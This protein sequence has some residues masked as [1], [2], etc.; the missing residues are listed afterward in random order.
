M[1]YYSFAF[2]NETEIFMGKMILYLGSAPRAAGDY[3]GDKVTGVDRGMLL[4]EMGH[5][6]M[7]VHFT[8]LSTLLI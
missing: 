4:L 1:C 7:E 2:S 8:L 3:G 5:R 6:Y